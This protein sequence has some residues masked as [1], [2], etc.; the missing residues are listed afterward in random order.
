MRWVRFDS[1]VG[2]GTKEQIEAFEARSAEHLRQHRRGVDVLR[3]LLGPGP[4]PPVDPSCLAWNEGIIPKLAQVTYDHRLQSNGELDPDRL[5][6]LADALLDAGCTDAV[7][8]E[9]L[10][11]QGPHVR[12]CFAV[13]ALLGGA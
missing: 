4:F 8:L 11:G 7:L 6:V 2:D 13:N 5:V 1:Q 3:D 12:G 10:R 9:H